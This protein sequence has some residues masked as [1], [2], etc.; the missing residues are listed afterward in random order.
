M[1]EEECITLRYFGKRSLLLDSQWNITSSETSPFLSHPDAEKR[2]LP[3][4]WNIPFSKGEGTY[5]YDNDAFIFDQF[6][7]SKGLLTGKSKLTA[8]PDS[9]E[10]FRAPEMIAPGDYP[11]PVRFGRA[12]SSLNQNGFSDH[13]PIV[14]KV[15]ES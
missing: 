9:A 10:V 12:S 8:V 6:L 11:V 2:C 5:Y 1:K 3:R 4:F 14:M 13:F 15:K 7:L